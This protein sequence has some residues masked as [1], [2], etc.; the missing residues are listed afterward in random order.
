MSTE[1]EFMQ[2]LQRNPRNFDARIGL[3]ALL[4][5]QNL[6]HDAEVH[7]R[8]AIQL[9]ANRP[10]PYDLMGCILEGA[11]NPARAEEYYMRCY[12][13]CGQPGVACHA[14]RVIAAQGPERRNLARGMYQHALA[15]AGALDLDDM[16]AW[17]DLEL[18]DKQYDAA[19]AVLDR[20]VSPDD[21]AWMVKKAEATFR[22]GQRIP[23]AA[24]LGAAR[25]THLN[26]I[27]ISAMGDLY[28]RLDEPD[29][30]WSCWAEG[31]R[32]FAAEN[33]HEYQ[34]AAARNMI[35]RL[36]SYYTRSERFALPFAKETLP[37]PQ[38]IFIV[39]FPRSG[40]TLLE[41]MLGSHTDI[42]AGD[43]LQYVQYLTDKLPFIL[44][45]A[46][47]YPEA[48]DELTTGDQIDSVVHL[49]NY[50]IEQVA[51]SGLM[52]QKPDARWFTDKMPGNDLHLPL[53]HMCWPKSLLI[54]VVR[55]PLDVMVSM[56]GRHMGHGWLC[57]ASLES[58]AIHYV[59]S[60]DLVR[61]YRNSWFGND[62]AILSEVRYEE[63]ITGAEP[64]IRDLLHTIGVAWDG[65]CMNFHQNTR[66]SRSASKQQ[67][68]EPIYDRSVNRYKKYL[69]HLEPVLP[70]LRPTIE[71][72]GYVI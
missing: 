19:L 64:I 10:E 30:A 2:Q 35:D 25:T 69:H 23:T 37:G 61:D 21:D 26:P 11:G 9:N 28:D 14:A 54:H 32:R 44:N 4:L 3:S 34:D 63:L 66:Q 56:L 48:L 43:E 52:Q 49:R 57:S 65:N 46:L 29:E 38:P 17:T 72:L 45:S 70:I 15:Q 60:M 33:G 20:I 42:L 24:I 16:L 27:A 59:R 12:T 39:G 41:Q 1:Q 50:Y 40:T 18:D 22:W 5:T 8:A 7:A 71:R 68:T 51:K 67:I 58:A 31:K 53:L 36:R 55:H 6:F 62:D 13:L 47:S